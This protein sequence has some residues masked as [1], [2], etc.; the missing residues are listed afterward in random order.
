MTWYVMY[1]GHVPG[2]YDDWEQCRRQ[3]HGFSGNS[4]KG[5]STM[6][7]A[8]ARYTSYL[9]GE[10]RAMWRNRMKTT[11]VV[12]MPIVTAFLFYAIL[13]V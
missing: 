11:F 10:R 12:M 4:F 7:E 8:R 2:V 13:V 9:A 6:A 3:V 5:F 1:Q